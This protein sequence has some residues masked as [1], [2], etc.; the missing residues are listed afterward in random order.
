MRVEKACHTALQKHGEYQHVFGR[1]LCLLSVRGLGLSMVLLLSS[2]LFAQTEA[3]DDLRFLDI[4][5]EQ[6]NTDESTSNADASTQNNIVLPEAESPKVSAPASPM[7]KEIVVTAQ[8]RAESLQDTP[9]ALTAFNEEK[10]EIAGID[11][12]A[13]LGSN[14]PSLQVEPFPTSSATLRF[15]IRGMGIIDA[16]ITQ[17]P[18]VGVYADGIYIARSTGTAFDVAD[19]ERVEILRGPQG[20]LYGRN[21]TGGAIN[22]ISKRPSVDETWIRQGFTIGD[23]NI[24]IV[25]SSMNMPVLDDLAVKLAINHS[26]QDGH[27]EN[28]GPGGDYGDRAALALRFDVRWLANEAWTVDYS[29]DHSDIEFYNYQ[30]QAV[31]TPEGN[32][33]PAEQVKRE[34]QANS[35]YSDRKLSSLATGMPLEA[36]H[37][38]IWGH[39]LTLNRSFGNF[40]LKYIAAW[41]RLYEA[42]YT[43][44]GGGAGSTDYRVDTHRY[45]GP[46]ATSLQGGPV[47]L[48]IPTVRQQQLS[49]ELQAVGNWQ[50]LSYVL[51]LFLF[52]EDGKERWQPTTHQFSA[53]LNPA[54]GTLPPADDLFRIGG[55]R[56]VAFTNLLNEME[57][58]SWAAF[59]QMAWSPDIWNQALD[60]TFGYRHTEDER[61]AWR[62][63]SSPSYVETP[64][65]A[66]ELSS[67]GDVF[68]RIPAS[69]KFSDDAISLMA[70]FAVL[71]DANLYAKYVEAYKS[72]GFNTRD[73][74][75]DGSEPAEDG[76][77]YG[78]GFISGFDKELVTSLELGVKSEWWDRRLRVNA[79]VFYTDYDDMQINFILA[80]TISDTKTTNAGQA[81][82]WGFEF[83]T[84]VVLSSKLRLDASYM[85][86][87]AEIT[88]VLDVNNQDVTD[89]FQFNSAP[90][91]SATLNL[92]ATVWRGDFGELQGNLAWQF[93]DKRKGGANAGKPVGL[94]AYQL[95]NLRLGLNPYGQFWGGS[96]SAGIWVRNLL[97]EEYEISAVDN[98]PHADRAVLWGEPRSYGI[99]FKLEF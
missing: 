63:K 13:N 97:D 35:I 5:G 84:N 24:L 34:A 8:R 49:H 17:D 18:A 36:S 58:T 26:Q 71:D 16:Q 19:I 93:T 66:T 52:A 7:L 78:Y 45:D 57:N 64:V 27:V 73:P 32:K 56:I 43:D 41:R 87:D 65:G 44:L 12:L 40:D 68:D 29:F 98:L 9:I 42:F 53:V 25:R 70:E 48:M 59:G 46:A 62:T 67:S 88:E 74:Q 96:Y 90:R 4:A 37:T 82:M 77:T 20:T 33:G 89:K 60:L 91:H 51:G 38:R 14:V 39:A 10:L 86:L 6:Q 79:D 28:T 75:I 85:F 80:G 1:G 15:Y 22:V 55:P 81:R 69:R 99:D 50:A 3:E 94:P 83:D 23:R 31:L 30:Y 92:D 2:S 61:K 54:A 95:V 47:E 72:G 11:G 76:E 21:T